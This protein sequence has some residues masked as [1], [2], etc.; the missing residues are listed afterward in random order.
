MYDYSYIIRFD[1]SNP[2]TI[3][4]V[5]K[6]L[7]GKIINPNDANVLMTFGRYYGQAMITLAIWSQ[8]S[9]S[10]K[11]RDEHFPAY[12][13]SD[14]PSAWVRNTP[15]TMPR[16]LSLFFCL[17]QNEWRNEWQKNN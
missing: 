15:L 14:L 1:W 12:F 8:L 7:H 13:R 3:C 17:G 10:E 6:D 5:V 9:D 4:K 11:L 2:D 16:S